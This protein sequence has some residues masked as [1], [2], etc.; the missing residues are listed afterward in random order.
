MYK[1]LRVMKA[2]KTE[3]VELSSYRLRGAAYS[4]FEMWEDSRGEERPPARWDE[5]VDAFMDHFLPAETMAARA[6]DF[7]VHKQG[8]M[9]VWEYHM[10]FVRLSKY[11]PQLVS[12]MGDRV[13][14]FV[15]GLSPLVVNEA[16]TVA[17]HS[18]MNYGKI[19]GFAQATEARKLKI[20]EERESSESRRPHQSGRP[21]G[22]SQQHGGALCPKCGRFHTE[23]CYLD[24]PVCYRCGVRG[25][26]QRDCQAPRQGTGRGFAQPS[27]SLA[28]TSSACPPA[29]A[30]HGAIRGRDHGR[31]GPSRFYALSGC[32]SV[33]ASPDVVTR[34]LSVQAIDYY[35]L[36][37]QGSSLSYVT[38]FIASS[39]GVEP[40][41]LHESFSVSTPVGDF[42]T[43]ARVYRNCVVT[44]CGRATTANLIEHGMVDFY[45]IMG[46]DWLYSCFPKLDYRT[47]VMRLEFPNE[48]VIEWK[49]NGVVP[50]DRFISYLK[51]SK[52]IRRGCIYHLVQVAD[53]TSEVSA[54]KSVP[55]VNEFLEVFPDKLLGIPP[56]REI[57]FE[58]DVLPDTQ[59]ISIP[60]YRMAPAELRELKEQLKDLL[61]KGFI[62][63]SVSSWG[64][65]VLFVRKKD[66]SLR[67][68][69][70]YRQLNKV[71]IK[72]KYPL[73]RIDDLF[74]QLQ[75][76]RFFSK[77]DL[78]SGY[79]QLKIRE[80]DIPK[81]A[82][83]TRY[84]KANVVAD[85]LSRK[86]MGSLA[87]LGADHRSL[88]REVYQLAS[89][90]IKEAVLNNKTSAFSLG[91][92]DGV[93]QCQ[94]RLC[95]ADVDNLRDRVMAEAHNSSYSVH[96][97]STKMYHDLKEIYWWNGIKRG[98]ADFVTRCSNYHQVKAEHQRPGRLT[99]IIEIPMWKWEMINMDFVVGLSRT[100]RRFDSIWVIVDRL[101]KS[102]HFLLVK[103]SDTAEQ[104]D[105]LYIK[106]IVRLHD[107]PVS[108]IS[109]RGAQFTTNFWK[110]FQQG[111]GTQV[112]LST[113]FHPQTD[114]QA[115]RTIQTLK[116][117]LRACTLDFKG[118][119]HEGN[120]AIWE[121][122]EIKSEVVG[123]S[124]VIVP[125]EAIEVNEE[126]SN[127]EIPVAILDRQVDSPSYKGNSGE[128]LGKS[129]ELA[130]FGA[131]DIFHN[132]KKQKLHKDG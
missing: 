122:R 96:P 7:E 10:E 116:D 16:A 105:Q 68:C 20:R 48:P 57:D 1:T 2:T 82:F 119:P 61:E 50:K 87:H 32:Q 4:L 91:G 121:E 26:I 132:V 69:I 76:A 93:L 9:S 47:R 3:G 42:I 72:N 126:L 112:N 103:S 52:M 110:K 92:G 38:P 31:S 6:T 41:Q 18:D 71:A 25:H 23:D 81:N 45:V 54:P 85:A 78:R 65:P 51:A 49:G 77:I 89:M 37:D 64:A 36:I 74:D 131:D 11:A 83:R 129:K 5:F 108:I 86:S 58:I 113:A 120:H 44:V 84:G 101:T 29:P 70:D 14:L 67:M 15:Q 13:R 127:E 123:D 90:G 66:G 80:Q 30:G 19:V 102:A 43:A 117:M 111:L 46:M 62:R 24:I 100:P 21:R 75:G 39:F 124:F 53:T 97:G 27:G 73:P 98:V 115:E 94:G 34:I 17:L 99:Q 95:V 104:Y 63:L 12:T 106:E 28:A 128:I 59:P 130:K 40:E 56:D 79:H 33:E 114:G 22:G 55:V 118:F 88:A 107:T 8:S 60:P 125:I 109:D 35:A